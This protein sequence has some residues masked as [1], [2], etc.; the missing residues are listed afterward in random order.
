MRLVT[1]NKNLSLASGGSWHHSAALERLCLGAVSTIP[2]ILD[3]RIPGEEERR[4]VSRP[5]RAFLTLEAVSA[6]I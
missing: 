4:E 3:E 5:R 2:Q 6:D 1:A